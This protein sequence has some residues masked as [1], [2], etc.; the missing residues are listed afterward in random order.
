MPT[1]QLLR[2]PGSVRRDLLIDAWMKAQP[3]QLGP[4]AQ[5][6]FEVMRAC[7]NDVREILH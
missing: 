2:F 1:N 5:R 4:I 7:G 3:R 6:W